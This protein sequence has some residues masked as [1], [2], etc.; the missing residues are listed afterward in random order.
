MG[1]ALMSDD[2]SIALLNPRSQWS[3]RQGMRL[4]LQLLLE[5]VLLDALLKQQTWMLGLAGLHFQVL[6]MV[7]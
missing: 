2:A 1:L 4:L 7:A 3:L 6:G 5:E